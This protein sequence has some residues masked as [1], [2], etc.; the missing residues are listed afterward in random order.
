MLNR[1]KSETKD[2]IEGMYV[3]AREWARSPVFRGIVGMALLPLG[4]PAQQARPLLPLP[5]PVV[6]TVP[7]NGDV[8]PY[9]VAF[10]PHSFGTKGLLHTG[11]I[12]VSNFNN[13]S[14]LQG[15]GTTIIR[16]G[17]DGQP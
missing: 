10:V 3:A 16:I 12:L 2:K 7:G 6:S 15:T 8:N 1:S 5:P 14:N 4:V 17:E 13:S 9:G 11:D